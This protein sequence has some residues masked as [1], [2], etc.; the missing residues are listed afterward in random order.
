MMQAAGA[1][2][3][4]YEERH[5]PPWPLVRAC[6]AKSIAATVLFTFCSE[7]DNIPHA[8]QLANAVNQLLN[9]SKPFSDKQHHSDQVS[10]G[11]W[12]IPRAWQQ[13][14]GPAQRAY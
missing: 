2:E 12:Q 6:Q 4:A 11:R 7:G 8:M 10:T 14:Y 9:K 1:A 13:L 3:T 5:M